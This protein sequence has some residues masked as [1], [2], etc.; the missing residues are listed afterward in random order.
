MMIKYEPHRT[1][2]TVDI[3]GRLRRG[4]DGPV[5]ARSAGVHRVGRLFAGRRSYPVADAR[6]YET[7]EEWHRR[8]PG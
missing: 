2:L 7:V 8:M 6:W 4:W 3:S 1:T 5:L